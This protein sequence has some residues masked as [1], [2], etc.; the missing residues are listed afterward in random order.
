MEKQNAMA[1]LRHFFWDFDGTL[2][3]T[4]PLVIEDLR[5][6]LQEYGFDCDPED[7]MRRMLDAIRTTRDYYADQFGIDREALH[8]SFN[9]HRRIEFQNLAAKPFPEVEAVLKQICAMNGQNY[10]FTHSK[11]ENI[12]AYL[13]KYGLDGYFTDVLGE[14]SPG[15]ALKPSP[16]SLFYLMDKYGIDPAQAVMIGDRDRDLGSGRAAGIRIAHFVCAAIPEELSCDWRFES[17]SE[18]LALLQEG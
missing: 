7:A 12:L 5:R 2:F 8:A 3:D 6:S 18:M 9:R 16:D 17:F 14:E 11:A 4:Y 13:V 15:F 1:G 10:I